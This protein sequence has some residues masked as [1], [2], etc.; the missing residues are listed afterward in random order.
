MDIDFIQL[1]KLAWNNKVDVH[2]HSEFY[3]VDGFIQQPFSLNQIELDLLGNIKD[4]SIL[5][6]QCHFGQDTISLNKLGATA[7]GVD[8]SEKAIERAKELTKLTNSDCQFICSDIYDLPNQLNQ[9]FDVVF[10]SYG[11]IGW[12][13]DLNQWAG[14]VSHFLKPGGLFVFAEFHPVVWMFDNDINQIAYSYFK[15]EPIIE[16]EKGTYADKGAELETKTIS[17]N[18][19]LS[20]VFNALKNNHIQVESF[21]EFNYSPYNCFQ[22]MYEY[23]KGKFRFEKHQDKLPLVYSLRGVKTNK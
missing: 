10:T 23:E 9:Q 6:L 1:N 18:H 17:W 2:Y 8:F 12:L 5:H 11:T 21:H 13:P 7:T 14:V 3:Q 15:A 16:I 20:E 22:G 4:K 19:S